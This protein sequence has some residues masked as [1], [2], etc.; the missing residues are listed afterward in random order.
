MVIVVN[1]V[2]INKEQRM[3]VQF[4][5]SVNSFRSKS[6]AI[7]F[8][9]RNL[10]IEK[11]LTKS[12]HHYLCKYEIQIK[13]NN[14]LKITNITDKENTVKNTKTEQNE[15]RTSTVTKNLGNIIL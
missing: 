5:N 6:F 4:A 14:V 15:I 8:I 3:D 11:A 10:L 7:C 13:G 1:V 9:P 12:L 2:M